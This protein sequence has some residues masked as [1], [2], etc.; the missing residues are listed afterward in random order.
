MPLHRLV[1]DFLIYLT[2]D[3]GFSPFTIRDYE[4]YMWR[5]VDWA[6]QK[7]Q[8]METEQINTDTVREYR[9]FLARFEDRKGRPLKRTTQGYHLVALRMFLRYLAVNRNMDV[10]PPD[11]IDLPKQEARSVKFLSTDEVERLL[12]G[13]ETAADGDDGL[14]ALRDRAIL[15]TLFSTGV[16][17]SE[18][19]ALN[20]D[21]L[22]FGMGA[23]PVSPSTAI[24]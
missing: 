5:F 6:D 18:L 20:R 19:V 1:S 22:D 23:L 10:M 12:D 16:R 14:R 11:R 13:P 8:V 3:R 21:N 4:H 7:G 15:E 17:V 9:L 2:V 24:R